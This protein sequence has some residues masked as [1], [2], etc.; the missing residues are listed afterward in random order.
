ML[1]ERGE[2]KSSYRMQSATSSA[3]PASSITEGSL[4]ANDTTHEQKEITQIAQS[5]S[6][7]FCSISL[8]YSPPNASFLL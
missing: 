2:W 7:L 3:R 8:S 5:T 6:L 1:S 4:I